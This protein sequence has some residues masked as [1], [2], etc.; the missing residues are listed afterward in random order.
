MEEIDTGWT[1]LETFG[2]GKKIQARTNE[3]AGV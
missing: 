1:G 3:A 2:R